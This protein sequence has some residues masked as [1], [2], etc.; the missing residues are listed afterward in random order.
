M[1]QVTH[2]MSENGFHLSATTTLDILKQF[3]LHNTISKNMFS[4][5]RID[6]IKISCKKIIRCKK[7]PI[8]ITKSLSS[9]ENHKEKI[10]D[11]SINNGDFFGSIGYKTEGC[12]ETIKKESHDISFDIR[13]INICGTN[14]S[15]NIN[16]NSHNNII[17]TRISPGL[18]LALNSQLSI[19]H[20]Y[21]ISSAKK[22]SN[23]VVVSNFLFKE[24][25]P[26][27]LN[28]S[29]SYTGKII[30][31]R[32]SSNNSDKVK[33]IIDSTISESIKMISTYY[34][35][36]IHECYSSLSDCAL[37]SHQF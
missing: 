35:D 24:L 31:L 1:Q 20:C 15:A 5:Y 2:P 22:K 36:P 32:E 33:L 18:A 7:I 11:F 3:L 37:Q 16:I 12:D 30:E 21:S 28:Q 8:T 23:G 13:K 25:G 26:T 14:I 17:N 19:I 10:L 34:F 29:V 27:P 6:W 9:A 4:A